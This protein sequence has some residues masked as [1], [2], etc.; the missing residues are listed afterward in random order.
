MHELNFIEDIY[1]GC[2][3]MLIISNELKC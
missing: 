1:I 2:F 3:R